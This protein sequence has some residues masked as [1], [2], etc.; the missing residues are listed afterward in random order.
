MEY[1]ILLTH[2]IGSDDAAEYFEHLR[3]QATN[4]RSPSRNSICELVRRSFVRHSEQY[5]EEPD[6]M[7]MPMHLSMYKQVLQLLGLMEVWIQ[8]VERAKNYTCRWFGLRNE[9]LRGRPKAS[10]TYRLCQRLRKTQGY[11]KNCSIWRMVMEANWM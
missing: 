1:M 4:R 9:Y 5:F 10:I 2:E 7:W 11:W 3:V 6:C 8:V